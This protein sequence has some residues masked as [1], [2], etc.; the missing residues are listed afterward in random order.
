MDS[1]SFYVTTS[2]IR[3]VGINVCRNLKSV[4]QRPYMFRENPYS[5]YLVIKCVQTAITGENCCLSR[6]G[7][8]PYHVKGRIKMLGGPHAASGLQVADSCRIGY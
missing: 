8:F 4:A 7:K 6:T 5:H 2:N 1:P 3:Y